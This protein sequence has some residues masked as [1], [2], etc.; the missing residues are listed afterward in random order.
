MRNGG[1]EIRENLMQRGKEGK[2][3]NLHMACFKSVIA[4]CLITNIC[5]VTILF[6]TLHMSIE[7]LFFQFKGNFTLKPKLSMFCALSQNYQHLF[8]KWSRVFFSK[9]L[10]GGTQNLLFPSVPSGDEV[11]W[12]GELAKKIQLFKVLLSLKVVNFDTK[13][14]FKFCKFS[15]TN[16]GWGRTSL[17]PKTGTRVGWQELT[18]F[19]L[20]GGTPS[21]PSPGKKPCETFWSK[22]SERLKNGIKILEVKQFLIYWSKKYGQF[23][24]EVQFLHETFCAIFNPTESRSIC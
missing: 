20:D 19:S 8:Q 15:G 6:I 10:I 17:G 11:G 9:F 16:L 14:V 3:A 24:F 18:N 5:F 23:W 7:I 13:N 2:G 22:L 21:P 12:G 4:L 1:K